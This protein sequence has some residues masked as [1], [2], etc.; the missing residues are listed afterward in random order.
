MRGKM[1]NPGRPG[2]TEEDEEEEERI[3]TQ[4][5][6][7]RKRHYA[8]SRSRKYAKGERNTENGRRLFRKLGGYFVFR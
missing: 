1:S 5:S 3:L 7:T 2:E 8:L 4:R 6:S